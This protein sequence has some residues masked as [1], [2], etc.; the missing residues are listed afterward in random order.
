M[1]RSEYLANEALHAT[2]VR[3]PQ[4]P[5][6]GDLFAARGPVRAY[7]KP[8]LFARILRAFV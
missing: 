2:A 1:S 7:R 3:G 6:A 5:Q 4:V 8:S